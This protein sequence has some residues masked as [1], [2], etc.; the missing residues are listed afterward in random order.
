VLPTPGTLEE[1]VRK[2]ISYLDHSFLEI[3]SAIKQITD[4]TQL[5]D[6]EKVR[7]IRAMLAAE[8]PDRHQAEASLAPLKRELESETD[9]EARQTVKITTAFWRPNRFGYKTA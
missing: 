9:G 5:D 4:S 6:A 1:A 7:Q 2:L 3:L 8:E